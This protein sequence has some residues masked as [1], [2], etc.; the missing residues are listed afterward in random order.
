M[1]FIDFLKEILRP[2]NGI[3]YP[4]KGDMVTVHYHG[5]L[6]DPTRSWGRGRR[7]DSSIKRGYPFTFQIGMGTVIKG[8]EV[9]VLGMSL[10]EKA[11][12]TFG[13]QYGYG[14]K[15]APPFIPGNANLVFTVEL[16]AINGRG[17]DSNSDSE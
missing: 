16:L 2:G 6:H 5:Y 9:G 1:G 12:L 3:D 14:E 11:L 10:G 13:P 17:L 8:W 7:F 15:G 4:Q